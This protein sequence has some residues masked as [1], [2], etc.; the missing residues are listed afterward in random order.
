MWS[1]RTPEGN[2]YHAYD[3]AGNK[4]TETLPDGEQTTWKYDDLNRLI[5]VSEGQDGAVVFV[6]AFVL[7]DDGT[8]ASS[9]QV[10]LQPG[11]STLITTDTTWSN[12]ALGRLTSETLSSSDS[13]QN[14]TD[15]FGYDLVGNRLT[16]QHT[17]PGNGP[18]ETINNTYN[19]DDELTKEVTT[20]AGVSTETD[21]KYDPNGSLTTS[22][23]PAGP[24]AETY[25]Y[26]VRNKMVSATVNGV[27][28]TYVCDDAG[29]RV[30]ETTNSGTPQAATTL[31]LTDDANPT[32]YAQPIEQ[33]SSAA[34]APSV[35][36]I[37]GDRVLAQA[38][39]GA[40]A[41][42][43]LLP[44]GHG[45]VRADQLRRRGHADIQLHRLRRGAGIHTVGVDPELPFRRRRGVRLRQRPVHERRRHAGP[46]SW[47]GRLHRK[48][49]A[50]IVKQSRS[51]FTP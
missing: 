33:K 37:I 51:H 25:G 17:G 19:G 21:L 9:H 46:A 27:T 13:T 50:W 3:L 11:G 20:S 43:Y 28:T 12:D 39:A 44:D 36:Y 4:K 34:A 32:G 45:S 41:V 24:P 7:N 49:S 38:G 8:R 22:E 29:N 6:Q 14:Y 42:S 10:Q 16:S 15:T 1:S 35:T 30:A 31:Y 5:G 48:R 47:R 26:D 23:P 40:A 18:D 2:I